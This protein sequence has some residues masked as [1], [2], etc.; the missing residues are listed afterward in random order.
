MGDQVL[1]STWT[2]TLFVDFDTFGFDRSHRRRFGAILLNR[3]N[4]DLAI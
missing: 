1:H 2:P 3:T 4:D